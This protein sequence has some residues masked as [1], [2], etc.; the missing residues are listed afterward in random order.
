[1]LGVCFQH[2]QL[3]EIICFLSRGGR[4]LHAR[5]KIKGTSCT[6]R[7]EDRSAQLQT[8]TLFPR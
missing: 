3:A 4:C 1:M 8:F 7:Y 6:Q 5:P 2:I